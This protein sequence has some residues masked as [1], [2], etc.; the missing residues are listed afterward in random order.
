MRPMSHTAAV[1]SV[2][3]SFAPGMAQAEDTIVDPGAARDAQSISRD[4][5]QK[6]KP[7]MDKATPKL[8]EASPKAV[9]PADKRAL[10]AVA[11]KLEKRLRQPAGK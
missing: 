6:V 8:P 2:C 1:L 4:A 9:A 3:L 10:E 5:A 7:A 11:P